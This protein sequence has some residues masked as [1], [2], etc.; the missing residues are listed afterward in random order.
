MAQWFSKASDIDRF[1]KKQEAHPQSYLVLASEN[2]RELVD[3]TR[4]HHHPVYLA[5]G[6]FPKLIWQGQALDE[7]LILLR[8][9][10]ANPHLL[11]DSSEAGTIAN[12]NKAEYKSYIVLSDGLSRVTE[13]TLKTIYDEL[14]A[15][16]GILGAG[17]GFSDLQPKPCLFDS[18]GYYKDKLLVFGIGKPMT[19][20]SFH[21]WNPTGRQMIATKTENNLI[22]Q[23]NW[24]PAAEVY[25]R[26][27]SSQIGQGTCFEIRLP[28]IEAEL[29]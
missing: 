25:K 28:L 9:Q 13:P 16:Q 21:G 10:H 18:S 12:W 29:S 5:G 1:F 14:G 17:A 23:I 27:V 22:Q 3:Y 11:V 24:E 2:S 7:G 6:F 4:T 26:E 20:N 15:G 8:L 19:V